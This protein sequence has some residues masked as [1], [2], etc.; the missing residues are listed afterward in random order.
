MMNYD[1]PGFMIRSETATLITYSYL[2]GLIAHSL[3]PE[4]RRQLGFKE[5]RYCPRW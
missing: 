1:L 4:W 2:K 3:E 5:V